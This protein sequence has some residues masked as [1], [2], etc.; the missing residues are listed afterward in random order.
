MGDKENMTAGVYR[1]FVSPVL[2]K[3]LGLV[4]KDETENPKHPVGNLQAGRQQGQ[5]SESLG[6]CQTKVRRTC[7][8]VVMIGCPMD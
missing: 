7:S 5:V 6:V 1:R 8:A 2:P 3:V 4:A